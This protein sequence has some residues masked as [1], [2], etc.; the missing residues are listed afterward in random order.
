MRYSLHLLVALV[1]LHS[2]SAQS[3]NCRKLIGAT[4]NNDV[5]VVRNLL[6]IGTD[7]NCVFNGDTDPR[8]ALNMAARNGNLDI[9]KL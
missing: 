8:T 3:K 6:D 2:T 7:P 5:E 4:R 1:A 9:G